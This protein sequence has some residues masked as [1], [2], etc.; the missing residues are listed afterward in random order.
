MSAD[1]KDPEEIIV[2][3]FDFTKDLG[4]ESITAASQAVAASVVSGVDAGVAGTLLGAPS[5]AGSLVYQKFQLGVGGNNYKL[6]CRVDTS[7]GR[8]LVLSLII[9]V[10]AA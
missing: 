2:A 10:R 8:R 9:P 6:R 3:T 7:A 5:V 4:T 1:T